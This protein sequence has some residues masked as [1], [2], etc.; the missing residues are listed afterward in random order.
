MTTALDIS[1]EHQKDLGWPR[2][3]QALADRASTEPGRDACLGLEFH[4]DYESAQETLYAVDE[5]VTLL[6]RGGDLPVTGTRN[7]QVALTKARR[8]AVLSPDELVAVART[9][10][11]CVLTRRHLLHHQAQHPRLGARGAVL[12][13]L[14]SLARSATTPPQ[15]SH[16]PG[17]A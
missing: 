8:G 2:I 11:S 6:T 16:P 12:P 15:S 7:I 9:A 4:E 3:L 5:L 14:Q 10:E 1:I 13:E 17:S